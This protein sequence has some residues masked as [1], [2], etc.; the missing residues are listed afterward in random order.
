MARKE[1]EADYKFQINERD[2]VI[3]TLRAQ[4][5]LSNSSSKKENK[6]AAACE[7]QSIGA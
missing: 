1:M 6:D 5:I 2:K 4:I 3:G 7:Q